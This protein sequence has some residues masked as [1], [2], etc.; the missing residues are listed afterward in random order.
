[1]ETSKQAP[2]SGVFIKCQR[3]GHQWVYRGKN[4]FFT[5]CTFCRTSISIKKNKVE[6]AL[7]NQDCAPVK[8]TPVVKQHPEMLKTD[9]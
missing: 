1:M 2:A 9:N 5:I 3:C 4:P 7:P 6:T 8:A